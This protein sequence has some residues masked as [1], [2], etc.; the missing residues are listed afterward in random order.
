MSQIP[1][2]NQIVKPYQSVFLVIAQ[3]PRVARAPDVR[4][5]TVEGIKESVRD[6]W[7]C[8]TDVLCANGVSSTSLHSADTRRRET[9]CTIIR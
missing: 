4:N 3:Q 5:Q 7:H 8:C 1:T 2:A 6:S 9:Y